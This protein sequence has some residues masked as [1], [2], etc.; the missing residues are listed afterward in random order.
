MTSATATRD[1]ARRRKNEPA[2]ATTATIVR[3]AIYTHK[4]SDEGLQQEFNSLDAQRDPAEAADQNERLDDLVT[5]QQVLGAAAF[6]RER[7]TE[8]LDKEDGLPPTIYHA[9]HPTHWKV[10]DVGRLWVFPDDHRYLRYPDGATDS[11]QYESPYARTGWPKEL[12]SPFNPDRVDQTVY[13][14]ATIGGGVADASEWLP[15]RRPM[16][17]TIGRLINASTRRTTS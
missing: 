5:E 3:C 9:M 2:K 14:R 11:E 6:W 10:A 7:F 4:S 1:P 16:G 17:N 8:D 12:Y 15:R 13:A